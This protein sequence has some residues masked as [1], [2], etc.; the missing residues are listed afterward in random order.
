MRIALS[1][2]QCTGKT[3]LM[4]QIMNHASDLFKDYELIPE[5]VRSIKARMGEHFEFNKSS[6]Y[7]SQD[8]ILSEHH[9]NV[10]Q[11]KKLVTD[12]CAVDAFAYATKNYLDGLFSFSQW[13]SFREIFLNTVSEYDII[14][15][16][17]IGMIPLE[18]DGVRSIDQNYQAEM[19][20]IFQW[21]FETYSVNHIILNDPLD[22]RFQMLTGIVAASVASLNV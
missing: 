22:Q 6:S 19:D 21:V 5:V 18:D 12:R 4:N 9:R 14:F 10:L 17:P 2:V 20:T 15:Y 13:S 16:L 3:T 8:L 11:F 7:E 1:G